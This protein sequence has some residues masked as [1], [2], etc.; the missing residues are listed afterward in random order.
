MKITTPVLKEGLA[1]ALD[2]LDKQCFQAEACPEALALVDSFANKARRVPRNICADP[3]VEA[4]RALS[5]SLKHGLPAIKKSLVN[6]VN[7]ADD[8]YL[9]EFLVA[10]QAGCAE[11][12]NLQLV[13]VQSKNDDMRQVQ[14]SIFSCEKS[15]RIQLRIKRLLSDK[16]SFCVEF[17]LIPGP[18]GIMR[19]AQ[20]EDFVAMLQRAKVVDG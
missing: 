4:M 10:L 3:A 1:K 17:F 14:L 16:S 13:S 8:T 11:Y 15:P 18:P 6:A 19:A 12:L 9:S 20:D 2:W 7:E 5:D